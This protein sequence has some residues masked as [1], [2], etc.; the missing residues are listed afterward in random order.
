MQ[1]DL[2]NCSFVSNL[3]QSR[4]VEIN[5]HRIRMDREHSDLIREFAL[6]VQHQPLVISANGYFNMNLE[7]VCSVSKSSVWLEL[8]TKLNELYNKE[9]ILHFSYYRLHRHF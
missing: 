1:P 5:L 9:M 4:L 8:L 7:L 2:M 3:F 6:E